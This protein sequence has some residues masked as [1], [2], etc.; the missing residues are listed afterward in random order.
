M[1]RLL[2]LKDFN[3]SMIQE[4]AH[5]FWHLIEKPIYIEIIWSSGVNFTLNENAKVS[6]SMTPGE[7]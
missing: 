1:R 2:R 7:D 4:Q 5:V 3:T 6:E